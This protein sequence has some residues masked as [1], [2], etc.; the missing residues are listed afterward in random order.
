MVFLDEESRLI[1][2]KE[3]PPNHTANK[4]QS[5]YTNTN[6]F[7]PKAPALD[8]VATMSHQTLREINHPALNLKHT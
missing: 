8:R 1:Q 7:G 6:Q 3:C 2:V 5:Y 4:W